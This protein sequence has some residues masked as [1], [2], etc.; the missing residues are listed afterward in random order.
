MV[1]VQSTVADV[2]YTID[3]Q[4]TGSVTILFSSPSGS[5]N[6]MDDPIATVEMTLRDDLLPGAEST[7]DIDLAATHLTDFTGTPLAIET[8]SGVFT[9]DD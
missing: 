4:P 6:S 8:R 1:A 5:L 3:V 2:S 7:I 9:V